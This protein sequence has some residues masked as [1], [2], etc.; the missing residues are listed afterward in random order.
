M[1][2]ITIVSRA[3]SVLSRTA[4][5][6]GR[7]LRLGGDFHT[8]LSV[9]PDC[10]RG[11]SELQFRLRRA[12]SDPHRAHTQRCKLARARC[13]SPENLGART[14]LGGAIRLCDP[15]FRYVPKR[16]CVQRTEA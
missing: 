11:L 13:C 4:E 15:R 7:S 1:V 10:Y 12:G 6:A 2:T 16:S 14:G 8:L 3:I 9:G 5:T